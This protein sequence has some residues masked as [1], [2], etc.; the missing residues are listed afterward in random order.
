[1]QLLVCVVCSGSKQA[2]MDGMDK[3]TTHSV[4]QTVYSFMTSIFCSI[5]H[6]G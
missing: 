5:K 2:L 3:I 6:G 1:M 4:A